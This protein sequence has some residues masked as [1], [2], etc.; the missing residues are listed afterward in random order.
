TNPGVSR[1]LGDSTN[2][3]SCWVRGGVGGGVPPSPA[4]AT[5]AAPAAKASGAAGAACSLGGQADSYVFAVSWQ[6]AFCESKP[7]KPECSIDDPKVY[8][9]THFTLHGL[10]PNKTACGTNYGYC[11]AVKDKPAEFCGYPAVELSPEVRSQLAIVMPSVAS[12][13]CLERHEWHKHGTCQS[14]TPDQYYA[15]ATR[16]VRE[17]NDSGAAAFM[18][19][20]IGQQVSLEDFRAALD[21]GLGAGASRHAKLGCKD[22][23]L[24]DIYINLPAELKPDAS[25][26]DLLAQ[27]PD[28]P[29]DK[30]CASGFRVDP[31][32]Q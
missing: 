26:K 16:L 24:V 23:L 13:S 14:G 27:S 1:G 7:D 4:P 20:H 2:P 5:P 3:S 21:Q 31:I 32:G 30:T 25:L 17:F 18:A 22:G 6:P 28:A 11:G 9:A 10:W 12:G 8:Q 15:L 29:A 19:E